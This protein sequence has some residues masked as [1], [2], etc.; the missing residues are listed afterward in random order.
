[1]VW[2]ALRCALFLDADQ[3]LAEQCRPALLQT[4]CRNAGIR[5][6]LHMQKGYDHSYYFI[7]TFTEDHLRLACRTAGGRPK[8]EPHDPID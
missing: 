2:G 6:T 1:M 3:F 8:V 4:A 5:L 7:A